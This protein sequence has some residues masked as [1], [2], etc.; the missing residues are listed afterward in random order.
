MAG[1]PWSRRTHRGLRAIPKPLP[2]ETSKTRQGT[3]TWRERDRLVCTNVRAAHPR[4]RVYRPAGRIVGSRRGSVAPRAQ[5]SGLH[6][7]ALGISISHAY[8]RPRRA[9]GTRRRCTRKRW[10]A[11]G[12]HHARPTRVRASR[13]AGRPSSYAPSRQT[14][15]LHR[16]IRWANWASGGSEKLILELIVVRVVAAAPLA[17]CASAADRPNPTKRAHR[18]QTL[19]KASPVSAKKTPIRHE[20]NN[21]APAPAP[22]NS[23]LARRPGGCAFYRNGRLFRSRQTYSTSTPST[24]H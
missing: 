9:H 11:A 13:P 16:P 15:A 8:A 17:C 20:R 2:G 3:M 12:T 7:H 6:K 23:M 24:Q 21:S 5:T 14:A 19:K 4:P 10:V 22:Q 1:E 18:L